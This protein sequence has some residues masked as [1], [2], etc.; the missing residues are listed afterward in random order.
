MALDNGTDGIMLVPDTLQ[1]S[2]FTSSV[3][4]KITYM[5]VIGHQVSPI[6]IF[7]HT[8][9]IEPVI[10]IVSEIRFIEVG[11]IALTI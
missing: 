10:P 9:D 6:S 2:K 4:S 3:G 11:T 1:T 5:E 7:E 8:R